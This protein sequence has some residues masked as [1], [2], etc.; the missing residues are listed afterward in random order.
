MVID[1]KNSTYKIHLKEEAE[2]WDKTAKDE[3]KQQPPDYAYYKKTLPY[4]IYRHS[5]VEKMLY[6]IH[7]GDKVLELGCYNGWFTLEMA[8]KGA[9]ID[10][11]DIAK[12]ATEIAQ[13]YYKET[14]KRERYNGTISYC[15]TDLNFPNFPKNKYDV[16]VI[17]NVL[18]HIVNLEGLFDQINKALK[19][20]GIILVDDGLPVRKLNAFITGI[21]LMFFPI[22]IPYSQKLQRVFKKGNILKRTQ[23]AID[24]KDASPFEN[25]S[26]GESVMFL[27]R[28]FDTQYYTTYAAF[29]GVL[30]AKVNLPF[31]LKYPFLK[32]LN[33]IDTLLIELNVLQGTVYFLFGK[34]KS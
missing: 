21:F 22:D 19:K 30:T 10:A 15:V 31:V 8:R 28:L 3:L 27:K 33:I 7:S 23:G 9:Y 14:K 4:R 6:Y 16:V 34:K 20:G 13:Q 26:G 1:K 24:A 17:R 25:V 32:L 29:I 18:H 2:L 5:Y 12:K 11:H